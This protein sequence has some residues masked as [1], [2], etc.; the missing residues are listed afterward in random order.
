MVKISVEEI[1]KVCHEANRALTACVGDV[2]VQSPWELVSEDMRKSCIRGVEF[3]LANPN[4][5]ASAQH[6]AWVADRLANGWTL[7]PERSDLLKTHP[8][9]I[10]Y[11]QMPEHVQ[12]KDALF[13]AIVNALR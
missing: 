13:K 5:P 2:P 8:M 11:E 9:L 4:A 7:G 1:A 10:P 12:K 6:E 3:A